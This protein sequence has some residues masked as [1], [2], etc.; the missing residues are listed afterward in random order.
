LKAVLKKKFII[1]AHVGTVQLTNA[2]F[3]KCKKPNQS[4]WIEEVGEKSIIQFLQDK[5]RIKLTLEQLE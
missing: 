1:E 4:F 5:K 2:Q 3:I